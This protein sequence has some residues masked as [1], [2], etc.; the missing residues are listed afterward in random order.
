MYVLSVF[1]LSSMAL[2][3]HVILSSITV[4]RRKQPVKSLRPGVV[5]IAILVLLFEIR[6]PSYVDGMRESI[7]TGVSRAELQVFATD[8]QTRIFNWNTADDSQRNVKFFRE[9]FPRLLALSPIPP[10]FRITTDYVDVFYGS[11]LTK[12]WGFIVGDISQ[13][14]MGHIPEGMYHQVYD[15]VWVY[16]DTW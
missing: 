13:F 6:F 7:S 2:I 5:Y 10:R 1:L 16:H 3:I 12:H 11:A 15:G 8:V 14:P 4:I 9:K